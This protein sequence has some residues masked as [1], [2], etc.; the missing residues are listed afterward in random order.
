MNE[1]R[2]PCALGGSADARGAAGLEQTPFFFERLCLMCNVSRS[3]VQQLLVI[4]SGSGLGYLTAETK[5][6]ARGL[7]IVVTLLHS[8][9]A[10]PT[11]PA[12]AAR[13]MSSV[14]DE[15]AVVLHPLFR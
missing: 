6:G 13:K 10:R 7:M 1:R 2:R 3:L 14:L 11:P 15:S 9:H 12:A 4:N 8:S 5:Q